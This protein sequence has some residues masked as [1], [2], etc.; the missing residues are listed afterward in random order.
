MDLLRPDILL[1][2]IALGAAAGFLAGL[3]GIGGGIVLVPAFIWAFP[4]AGL[5]EPLVT[6]TAFGTSLAII[7]PT[8]ISSTLGHR[9]RG[10][11]EWHQVVPLAAGSM[12]GAFLGGSAAAFLPGL[13]LKGLFG[14]M[15][16]AISARMFLSRTY[17]PPERTTP[18]PHSH[19]IM[20]GLAAGGFSAFFGVGGGVVAVP[21]MVILLQLPIH[22]AVG[23]S[24]A[25]IVVSSMVGAL[26][27]V[28]HGWDICRDIPFSHGYVSFPVAAIIAPISLLM[29]RVGVRVATR[30]AHDKLLKAFAVLLFIVGAR[31]AWKMFS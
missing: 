16:I 18:V 23:N 29:A 11:V 21:L 30:T 8:A 9:K 22:R 13:L 3:L 7:F 27:Y 6:H 12:V 4:L 14:F 31:L 28:L 15:Q 10:N 19:L 24:C 17:L 5:P 25:L 1:I 2:L 20:V 26:S